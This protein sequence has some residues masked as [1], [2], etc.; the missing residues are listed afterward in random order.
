MSAFLSHSVLSEDVSSLF[1]ACGKVSCCA[2]MYTFV[3]IYRKKIA[4][5]LV[6]VV[7]VLFFLGGESDLL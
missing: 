5:S 6:F 7:F 2:I 1:I 3:Y 4:A